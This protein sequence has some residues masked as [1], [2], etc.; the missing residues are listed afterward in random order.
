[1][2]RK[3]QPPD[4][5]IVFA[6]AMLMAIGMVMVFSSSG[7]PSSGGSMGAL[8]HG[9][10]Y[11]RKQL[12]WALLGTV[13][14]IA[15][16]CFDYSLL[17]KW[18]GYIF[19]GGMLLLAAVLVPGLGKEV[20]GSMRWFDIGP[21]SFAPSVAIKLCMVIFLAASL[22]RCG[23]NIQLFWKGM[24]PHLA[25]LGAAA[26]LILA[27]PD[28]GT[29]V[30]IGGTAYLLFI[31]AGARALHLVILAFLGMAAVAGA[32]YLEPYRM[33]RFWAFLDPWKYSLGS[34]FQIIQSLYALGSG[35]LFGVGLGGSHQKMFYLPEQH[36][37]F[38]FSILGEELGYLGVLVVLA[39]FF[40]F[41]WRG[42]RTAWGCPDSF[43]CFLAAGI[44][45]MIGLQAIINIGVVS[46][47][48][49]VTGI[50]LPFISYGGSSLL[51]NMIGVGILLSVSR[52][53]RRA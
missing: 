34:G 45:S 6:V 39:L 20:S 8:S 42:F 19:L 35:G 26:G 31:M 37:D 43:G 11:L 10:Y 41:I 9:F 36:T 17:K 4:L 46:G 44:T 28:L 40:L 38:I 16:M 50:P 5:L 49:P 21:F 18:A 23:E 27:Q 32:I 33:A 22:S 15:A 7:I 52:D 1:M 30:S 14:L 48:L 2:R 25:A 24:A 53:Y 12:L 51:F 3:R 29:A 13:A 47:V